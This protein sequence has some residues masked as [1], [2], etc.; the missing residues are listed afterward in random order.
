MKYETTAKRLEWALEERNMTAQLLSD[1]SGVSKASISQYRHGRNIPNS[2]SARAM[3]AILG[4]TPEWLMGFGD[5]DI[6]KH[7]DPTYYEINELWKEMTMAQRTTLVQTA[8]I[9]VLSNRRE[10]DEEI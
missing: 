5:D 7:I 3:S 4:V 1:L 8:K 9:F 10:E 6:E 2:K